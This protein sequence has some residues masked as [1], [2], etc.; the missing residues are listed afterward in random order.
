M[1]EKK[2]IYMQRGLV[3]DDLVAKSMAGAIMCGEHY[4]VVCWCRA[5]YL[6]TIF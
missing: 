2:G 3:A 5:L 4:V 6:Q 1:E